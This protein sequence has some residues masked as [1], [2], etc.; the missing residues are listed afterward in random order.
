MALGLL[1]GYLSC[2]EPG[3]K[4]D[5]DAYEHGPEGVVVKAVYPHGVEAVV[6]KYPVADPLVCSAVV[7]SFLP[8][9]G[10]AQDGREKPYVGILF[11]VHGHPVF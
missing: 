11:S 3:I 1:G 6:V 4:V 10:V 5:T 9:G 7:V 2:L 8:F